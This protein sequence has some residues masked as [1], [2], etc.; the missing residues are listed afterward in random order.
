MSRSGQA[1]AAPGRDAGPRF[2]STSDA[3]LMVGSFAMPS[4]WRFGTHTHPWHQLA[5][6]AEGVLTVETGEGLWV[7]PPVRALWIPAG[8]P[9]ATAAHRSS[10]MRSPYLRPDACPVRWSA[11]TVVHVPPLLR[12]LIVHLAGS[13]AS[14]DARVRAEAV[15]CDLV[16]PVD[17]GPVLL[18]LPSDGRARRVAEA[19]LADPSDG[20]TLDAWGRAAGASGRTLARLFL[21][22]TGM[23]FGRWRTQARLRAALRLLAE[24]LPVAAVAGRVGYGTPSAFVAVFRRA[25]G[26]SPARYF[27]AG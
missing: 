16:E 10:V 19:L 2:P 15:L 26:V 23:S 20:R 27:T 3:S 12:E 21:A 11:P 1:A 6:A 14:G 7:L 17:A 24:G 25:F 18:P 22:E 9:H 8:V 5:W 4:R 13:R